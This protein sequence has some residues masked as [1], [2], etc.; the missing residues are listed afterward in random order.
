MHIVQPSTAS[1]PECSLYPNFD[2]VIFF[3]NLGLDSG[4]EDPGMDPGLDPGR[5]STTVNGA[6]GDDNVVDA[7]GGGFRGFLIAAMRSIFVKYVGSFHRVAW[8]TAIMI[9]AVP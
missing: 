8:S 6:M 5:N 7:A 1:M 9:Q 4:Y 3:L 2:S